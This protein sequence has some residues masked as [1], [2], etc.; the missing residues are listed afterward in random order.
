M[1]KYIEKSLFCIYNT[2]RNWDFTYVHSGYT[3]LRTIL[4]VIIFIF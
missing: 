1:Y 3:N 2:A 4:P